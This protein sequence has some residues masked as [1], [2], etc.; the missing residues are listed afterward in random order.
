MDPKVLTLKDKNGAVQRMAFSAALKKFSTEKAWNDHEERLAQHFQS[1][2]DLDKDS[3]ELKQKEANAFSLMLDLGEACLKYI[4]VN[5]KYNNE[6]RFGLP[7]PK[8]KYKEERNRVKKEMDNEIA[9]KFEKWCQMFFPLR[10][11]MLLP[12]VLIRESDLVK[13]GKL[14]GQWFCT[15]DDLLQEKANIDDLMKG[16]ARTIEV[17]S[18]L[19]KTQEK[20]DVLD[21][22]LKQ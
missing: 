4:D 17:K 3:E 16:G 12:D 10:G 21:K 19:P 20:K 5:R 8:N 15:K 2:L 18:A 1:I 6:Y 9:Q 22:V 11:K 7:M 13:Y 14:S